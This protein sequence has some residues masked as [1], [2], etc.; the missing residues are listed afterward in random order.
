VEN[1]QTGKAYLM[2]PDEF[3]YGAMNARDPMQRAEDLSWAVRERADWARL[4]LAE[5]E[6]P[7]GSTSWGV[8][9]VLDE[10]YPERELAADMPEHYARVAARLSSRV[11]SVT[12]LDPSSQGG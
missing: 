1:Q 6:R 3:Y 9:V 10:G 7:D 8:V 2:A 5:I 12:P 4:A 11:Q